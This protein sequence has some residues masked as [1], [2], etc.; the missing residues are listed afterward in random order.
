MCV[1]FFPHT[2]FRYTEGGKGESDT[3][4]KRVIF[5]MYTASVK[6]PHLSVPGDHT[7]NVS[8]V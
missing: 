8:E 5:S 6:F 7:I 4:I 3:G 1:L 2:K